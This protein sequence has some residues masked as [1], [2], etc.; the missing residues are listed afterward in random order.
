MY[1]RQDGYPTGTGVSILKAVEQL[2]F[3][4]AVS[5]LLD[6]HPAGWSAIAGVDWTKEIGFHEFPYPDDKDVS[7]YPQCYC[8]GDRSE[9][10]WVLDNNNDSGCEYA[11]VIDEGSEMLTVYERT[12]GDGSHAVGMFGLPSG[13]QWAHLLDVSLNNLQ[14]AYEQLKSTQ[15]VAYA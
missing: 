1:K 12:H 7:E 4:K 8:H 14:S 2:G 5:V 13:G 9:E 11:Y 15:E 3:K 6:E 10:E